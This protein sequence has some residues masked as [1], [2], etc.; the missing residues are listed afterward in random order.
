MGGNWESEYNGLAIKGTACD[1]YME[2]LL[3]PVFESI[4]RGVDNHIDDTAETSDLVLNRWRFTILTAEIEN[5]IQSR[6][7]AAAQAEDARR[8]AAEQREERKRLNMAAKAAKNE[9]DATPEDKRLL[10]IVNAKKEAAAIEK[11]ARDHF[12]AANPGQRF[13]KGKAPP[14]SP[15]YSYCNVEIF[16]HPMVELCG[17]H[18]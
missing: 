4:L 11:D 8:A 13:V 3:K 16:S 7:K 18:A 1:R 9:F 17:E 15:K 14:S 2:R 6:L 12:R 5:E 10:A